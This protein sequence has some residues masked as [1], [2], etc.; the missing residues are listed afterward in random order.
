MRFN[1]RAMALVGGLGLLAGCTGSHPPG[2][3]TIT[4]H[5]FEAG[6]AGR[7][8]DE[9]RATTPSSDAYHNAL[10]TD[11]MKYAEYEYGPMED[12]RHA[13]WHAQ[14]AMTAAKGGDVQPAVLSEWQLPED[15][16]GELSSARERLVAALAA[17]S[18][19]TKPEA[20]AQALASFN[21]WVEQQRENFQP[22]DIADCRNSFETALAEIEVKKA[23]VPETMVLSAD[24]LFAFGKADLKPEFEPML[25]KV[26]ETL[27]SNTDVR[28]LI[29][30]HTDTMGPASYNQTLS[31][32]RAKT[33]A[34][35][36]MS[37][38]VTA[39]RMTV[40]GVGETQLIVPTP[41]QTPEPKNRAVVISKR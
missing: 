2:Y 35:Y 17:G 40:T 7:V 5:I 39:D 16:M 4:G 1:L 6:P 22:Q 21:C 14:N 24:V 33:V 19:E 13:T 31:E 27:V 23:E 8:M 3:T 12:Y 32:R 28:I 36:L 26:A 38:G 18:P 34:D 20:S 37:K 9:A 15:K 29:V 10:Y 11:L 30:G 41:D 25:D